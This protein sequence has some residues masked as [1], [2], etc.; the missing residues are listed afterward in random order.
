MSDPNIDTRSLQKGSAEM[1]VLSLL[2]D[3][4][5]H[6]YEI[7]KLVETRSGSRLELQAASLY[8]ILYKLE[9]K[10][11]V[12]GKWVEKPNERRRRFYRLT[13]AGRRALKDMRRIWQDF[14]EAI[15]AIVD[16]RHA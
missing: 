6:G 11:L 9:K 8:P 14:V 2:E 16:V 4:Q 3:R 1:L 13:P 10:G 15:G 7:S 12:E 5:R